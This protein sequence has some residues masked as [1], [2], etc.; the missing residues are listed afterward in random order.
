MCRG[1]GLVSCVWSCLELRFERDQDQDRGLTTCMAR[2]RTSLFGHYKCTASVESSWTTA[3]GVLYQYIE[4]LNANELRG[5]SKL[6]R[7]KYSDAMLTPLFS[8]LLRAPASSA[9]VQRGLMSHW[10]EWRCQTVCWKALRFWNRSVTC[11]TAAALA[12]RWKQ[13]P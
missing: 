1:L 6:R 4:A 10:T 5:L 12:A 7:N 2:Q 9:S 3:Q 13:T 11:S 8:L